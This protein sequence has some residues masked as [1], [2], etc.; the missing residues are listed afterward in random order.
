MTEEKV[1]SDK[2]EL[3]VMDKTVIWDPTEINDT[4]ET[5]TKWGHILAEAQWE[6]DSLDAAYRSWRAEFG[7][8]LTE[9]NSKL[10]EW[11]IRQQIEANDKFRDY[12]RG[13]AITIRNCV[14]LEI[15]VS[16][17]AKFFARS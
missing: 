5:L 12:K 9:A 16:A 4:I 17:I 14:F 1:E 6:R 3:M 15:V 7:R 11:K 8:Q 13:M 10:P 2:V